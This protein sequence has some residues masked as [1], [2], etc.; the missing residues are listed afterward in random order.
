MYTTCEKKCISQVKQSADHSQ[1]SPLN[2]GFI[3]SKAMISHL[4]FAMTTVHSELTSNCSY[5]NQG[6][7]Q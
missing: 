7:T 5:S 1:S 3:T 2:I 4:V 6:G